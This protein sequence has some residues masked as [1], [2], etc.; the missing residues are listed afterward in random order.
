MQSS[1]K[2]FLY[3][4]PNTKESHGVRMLSRGAAYFVIKGS[5]AFKSSSVFFPE[6]PF[7]FT[8]HKK[9]E[10]LRFQLFPIT[11]GSL[12]VCPGFSMLIH[13]HAQNTKNQY[14]DKYLFSH[15]ITC[16]Y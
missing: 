13:L 16:A 9:N 3:L 15:E 5:S 8:P 4:Q 14:S 7:I 2:D 1:L 10:R 12:S 11:S 6:A